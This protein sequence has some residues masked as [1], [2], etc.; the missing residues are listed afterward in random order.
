VGVY[1]SAVTILPALL[2]VFM[3]VIVTGNLAL[4][5]EHTYI[6]PAVVVGSMI[7][8][9]CPALM[10]LALSSLSNSSRYVA[11]MYAGLVF[12]SEAICGVVSFVTGSSRVAWIS[13]NR[14]LEVVIDALFRQPPRYETPVVVSVLVLLCLIVVS[15]SVLERR[16]RGVEVVS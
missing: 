7:S 2:L 4:L 1:L 12:F 10:I 13:V 11:V 9:I 8:V 14:N 15:V 6:I 16:V 3:Q 5:R